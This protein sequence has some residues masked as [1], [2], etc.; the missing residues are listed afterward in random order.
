MEAV[1]PSEDRDFPFSKDS[2][3]GSRMLPKRQQGFSVG[4][5]GLKG[6]CQSPV[7]H[8][9]KEAHSASFPAVSDRR[10]YTYCS[11]I[12]YISEPRKQA[13]AE[14]SGVRSGSCTPNKMAALVNGP[15][16]KGC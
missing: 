9:F 2:R 4:L 15:I 7:G 11:T 16:E 14:E 1:L 8:I 10:T 12:K 3:V 13:Q 5:S 6:V